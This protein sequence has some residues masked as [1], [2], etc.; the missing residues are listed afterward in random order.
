M[1]AAGDLVGKLEM[2]MAVGIVGGATKVHP[3]PRLV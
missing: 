3:V 1:N 2:P